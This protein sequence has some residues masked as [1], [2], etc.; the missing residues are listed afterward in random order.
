MVPL[1][2]AVTF[3]A[4]LDGCWAGWNRI[5]RPHPGLLGRYAG[6]DAASDGLCKRGSVVPRQLLQGVE[7][8]IYSPNLTAYN[9]AIVPL[10]A[11]KDQSFVFSLL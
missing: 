10:T 3:L 2:Y 5:M 7:N 1:L 6:D 9:S 11:S 8:G 4:L